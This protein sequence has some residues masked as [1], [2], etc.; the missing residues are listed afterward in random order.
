LNVCVTWIATGILE[1]KNKKDKID[2]K[3]IRF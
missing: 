1:V 2:L 3:S